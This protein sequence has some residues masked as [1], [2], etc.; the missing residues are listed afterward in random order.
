M[1]HKERAHCHTAIPC[2]NYTEYPHVRQ[3]ICMPSYNRNIK[4]KN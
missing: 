3:I 1:A 4:S 2:H